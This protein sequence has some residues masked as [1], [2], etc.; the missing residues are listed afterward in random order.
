MNPFHVCIVDD[1]PMARMVA[2]D[3]L[4]GRDYQIS[5]C[6]TGAACLALFAAGDPFDFDATPVAPP[7][8]VLLDIEMP[9]MDGYEVCRRLREGGHDGTQVIFV[10]GRDDLESRLASFDAGGSDFIVK[11]YAPKELQHH[12]AKVEQLALRQREHAEMLSYAQKTA[13]SAMSSMGEMGAVLQFMRDSF[14]C[15]DAAALAERI[16]EAHR[17]Y[18]LAVLVGLRVGDSDTYASSQGDQTELEA[19]ILDY[20]RKLG[21]LQQLGNRLVLNYPHITLVVLDLPLA[22]KEKVDRL[23]D[24]LALIAEGAAA[25]VQGLELEAARA[26]QARGIVAAVNAL[27]ETFKQT[28]ALRASNHRAVL[29]VAGSFDEK[30]IY[31]FLGMGL[32]TAQETQLTELAKDAM[33]EIA[34]LLASQAE[35]EQRLRE[36]TLALERLVAQPA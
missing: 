30:L 9:E 16:I 17:A 36:V 2:A 27:T 24:H 18:G 23:R 11:P 14:A 25:R 1:D 31:A 7:D 3:A 28:A 10:S 26:A 13:F 15:Q 34:G 33:G 8:V 35:L 22:D 32:T 29:D 5:E 20:A 21:R 12:V 6:A 4:G 19:S